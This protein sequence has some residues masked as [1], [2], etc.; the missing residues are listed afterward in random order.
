MSK[1]NGT[2][3]ISVEQQL[4][5]ANKQINLLTQ[6]GLAV[7]EK[8]QMLMASPEIANKIALMDYELK[9]AEKFSKSGAFPNISPEQC[10]VLIRAG[11]EMGMTQLESMNSLY[12]VK[13]KIELY[14]KGMVSRLTK[15]GYKIKF[16][17]ESDKGVTV[18]VYNDNEHYQEDVKDSDQVLKNSKAMG[19]AK[20]NKM[21]FHGIRQ[22]GNFY[23]PHLFGSVN[24]WTEDDYQEATIVSESNQFDIDKNRTLNFI[25][26]CESVDDL[27]S[28]YENL[29]D[30]LKMDDEVLEAANNRKNELQ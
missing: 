6:R 13:G 2:A 4:I 28:A 19:F 15:A 29:P 10:Y 24:M 14:G 5:E 17:N 7:K 12:I 22:I 3:E 18:I 27:N 16:E 11:Q 20:K 23:L 1:Q 25:S 30:D 8:N 26:K 9:V 21:R